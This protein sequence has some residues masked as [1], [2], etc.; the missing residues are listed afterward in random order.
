[1]KI[2]EGVQVSTSDPWYDLAQGGYIKPDD[3]CERSGDAQRV[4][5]AVAVVKVKDFL[6]SCEEQIEG[7]LQ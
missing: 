6:Q 5:D 3:L 7:F 4:K 1:M 2:R